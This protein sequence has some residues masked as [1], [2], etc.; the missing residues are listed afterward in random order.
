MA[1]SKTN[2]SLLNGKDLSC[3]LMSYSEI[4]GNIRQLMSEVIDL[5]NNSNKSDE[6]NS[7]IAE[8]RMQV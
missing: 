2:D 4:C 5:K 7:E 1:D 8:L 3:N 6:K